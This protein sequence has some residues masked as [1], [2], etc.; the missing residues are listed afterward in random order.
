MRWPPGELGER[1]PVGGPH[2]LGELNALIC[3]GD[4]TSGAALSRFAA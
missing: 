3:S 4:R 2:R 1:L